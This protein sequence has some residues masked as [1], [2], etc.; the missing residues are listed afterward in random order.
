MAVATLQAYFVE[1]GRPMPAALQG[2][3]VEAVAARLLSTSALASQASATAAVDEQ[4]TISM[5]DPAVQIY[6]AIADD[7]AAFQA[8][9]QGLGA[10]EGE[11]NRQIGRAR[12][13]AYGAS[14]PPDATFSPR[15]TDGIVKGYDYNGTMAPPMT[16]LSGLYD[17]YYSFC[18]AGSTGDYCEW[19]LPQR[20]LDARDDLDLSTP[21]NF[22]ST[23]DTI[24]GNS[25]SPALNQNLELVGLNFDRTIE[26]LV[27]DYIYL[28]E[29]GRNVMV[30]VRMVLEALD[31]VY[32]LDG[33][34]TELTEGTL[35]E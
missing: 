6:A 13:G 25:G 21:V 33:L 30:D 4:G 14:V 34:V 20:W 22:V 1:V 11:L 5:D 12:F 26:G 15:I 2:P 10:R 8:A 31:D 3:S 18:E 29:R 32:D 23:S 35:R 24:G 28:P 27:R 9:A 19:E 7:V 17:R 16:T